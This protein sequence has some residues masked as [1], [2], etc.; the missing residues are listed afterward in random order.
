MQI[1]HLPDEQ[2]FPPH[3]HR[4]AITHLNPSS[5]IISGL[6]CNYM[7]IKGVSSAVRKLNDIHLSFPLS[8]FL[9]FSLCLSISLSLF[10]SFSLKRCPHRL[11]C[12]V[13]DF[14]G[15]FQRDHFH[16]K[17][18]TLGFHISYFLFLLFK[19]RRESSVQ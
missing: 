18:Q 3:E 12:D 5:C 13:S 6:M 2:P 11:S 17:S 8:L 4:I 16:R 9:S 1:W 14:C 19:W 7:C 10:C 15:L